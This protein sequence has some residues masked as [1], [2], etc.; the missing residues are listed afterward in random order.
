MI[1]QWGP[2]RII[3]RVIWVQLV[4]GQPTARRPCWTYLQS[5]A[6]QITIMFHVS[7]VRWGGRGWGGRTNETLACIGCICTIAQVYQPK[8]TIL[9][10]PIFLIGH[11]VLFHRLIFESNPWETMH[12]RARA[13]SPCNEPVQRARA[14]SPCNEPVQRAR[15]TSPWPCGF[16]C[17]MWVVHFQ[18]QCCQNV[19]W[20]SPLVN[21]E[22]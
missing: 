1:N 18:S 5:H 21:R 13:T 12:H 14:T 19:V 8:Q 10:R 16:S 22:F 17:L 6:T 15:A 3:T 4:R 11:V 9:C 2:N 7:A 20:V